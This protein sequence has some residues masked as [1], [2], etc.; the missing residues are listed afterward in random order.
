MYILHSGSGFIHFWCGHYDK[1][2]IQT[3]VKTVCFLIS[4]TDRGFIILRVMCWREMR[5]EMR[6]LFHYYDDVLNRKAL[7][8]H[9]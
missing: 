7:L 5:N 9:L 4:N 6:F 2:Q 8:K 3:S 1:T